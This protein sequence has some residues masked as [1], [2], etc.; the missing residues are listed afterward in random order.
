MRLKPSCR[1]ARQT[2]GP[3]LIPVGVFPFLELSTTAGSSQRELCLP[4]SAGVR[5]WKE[6]VGW[7]VWGAGDFPIAGEVRKIRGRNNSFRGVALGSMCGAAARGRQSS[8]GLGR[9]WAGAW[10]GQILAQQH[11][12]LMHYDYRG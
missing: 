4:G 11:C 10:E 1:R 9:A 5:G 3:C 12:A 7:V 6:R 8:P 2:D